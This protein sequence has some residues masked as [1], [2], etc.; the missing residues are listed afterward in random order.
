MSRRGA[1]ALVLAGALALAGCGASGADG[2]TQGA[3]YDYGTPGAVLAI[4]AGVGYYPACGN[5]TLDFDDRLWFPFVP[6][7]AADLPP[8]PLSEMPGSAAVDTAAAVAFVEGPVGAV[9]APGPGDDLGTL[10]IYQNDLA[11]WESDSS[12]LST[13]LTTSEIEYNWVC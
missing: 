4:Y 12:A 10:V 11:Y 9:V 2:H 6:S 3:S 8:D 7:N 13:W 1:L 5:E